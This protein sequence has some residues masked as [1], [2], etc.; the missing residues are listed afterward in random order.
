GGGA[1]HGLACEAVGVHS[2]AYLDCI[3]GIAGDM[4]LAALIDA[5]AS[6]ERLDEVVTM[7]ELPRVEIEI[8]RVE[9]HGIGALQVNVHAHDPEH[10]RPYAEIRELIGRAPLP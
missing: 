10:S 2:I 8:D 4:L 1:G 7:L 5:G 9:R 3:G 6:R